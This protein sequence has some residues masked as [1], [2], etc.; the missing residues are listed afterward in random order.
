MSVNGL[1]SVDVW[2]L[3]NNYDA[4]SG[5]PTSLWVE[6]VWDR[7]VQFLSRDHFLMSL[8][9]SE[10]A[11]ERLNERS[12]ARERF[13]PK[14]ASEWASGWANGRVLTRRFHMRFSPNVHMSS[15]CPP[16]N[17][18]RHLACDA[19]CGMRATCFTKSFEFWRVPFIST[20][21]HVLTNCMKSLCYA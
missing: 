16:V 17:T 11:S 5:S 13:E 7:R 3:V 14:E 1:M 6:T 4:A 19:S 12:G 9:E 15:S 10:W 8:A 20:A 2:Q 21:V 18:R